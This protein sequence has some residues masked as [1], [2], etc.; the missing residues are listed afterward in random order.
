[1][2][3]LVERLDKDKRKGTE[4]LAYVITEILAAQN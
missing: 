1:M 4:K 2:K 3:A